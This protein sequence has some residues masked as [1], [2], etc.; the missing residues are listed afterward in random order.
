MGHY[1]PGSDSQIVQELPGAVGGTWSSPAYFNNR[2]YY[3]GNGDR[4]KC[5]TFSG[6][7]LN[8][9][10]I[11]QSTNV[12][13][14]RGSTPSISANGNNNAI[15]WS[16]QTD[17][18]GN[19]TPAVLHAF[20][21]TNLSLELYNSAQAANSRDQGP[22]AVKFTLPTIANGKVY[23][24]GQ[25]A[26]TV[27]GLASFINPPVISPNGGIFTNSI[28]VSISNSTP[29]VVM[30]Y[31]L[32]STIP[33]SNSIPYNGPFL[34]TNSAVIKARAFKTGAVPSQVVSASFFN[35]IDVGTGTGLTG[36]YYSNH[37]DFSGSPTLV[38]IDPTVNFD[39]GN[40]SPD[41]TISADHFT[42]RWTGD[43]QPLFNEP[44]TFYTRTD[45]GVRLYVDGNLIINEWI[46]Q[47][48]T[49]WSA[50]VNLM[51]RR[52]YSITMEYYENGGG[53]VAQLSWSSPSTSKTIIPASQL[54]PVHNSPPYVFINSPLNGQS[55][56]AAATITLNSTAGDSDGYVTSVDY[57]SGTNLL[58][59]ATNSPYYLTV[60]GVGPGNLCA[61]RGSDGQWRFHLHVGHR[62]YYSQPRQRWAVRVDQPAA[63][64]R[65]LQH[66]AAFH[67]YNSTDVV[68]VRT[69]RQYDQSH[70]FTGAAALCAQRTL[71]V[72]LLDRGAVVCRAQ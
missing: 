21:A 72:G 9:T 49:E 64:A 65:L 68:P 17:G 58:G 14:D 48:P 7:L 59:R 60:P 34:L 27:Y 1:H 30:F 28:G 22:P 2:I 35:S 46:D 8:P 20:N 18:F 56:S 11:N 54:Y 33:G 26:L 42:V 23:V 63:C 55:F 43:V 37:T 44:Y 24:G 69:L 47:G 40:G 57:Y 3:H 5:F 53:A 66:A 15:L 19:G 10:P 16:L 25:Y 61:Q 39:W 71:L 50:T 45:D 29:A 4:I 31:T 62:Q 51:A 36:N 32:D 52:R 13:G 41:P 67:R 70:R 38:R 6:G 12:Y